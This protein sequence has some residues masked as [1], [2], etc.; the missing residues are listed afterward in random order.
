MTTESRGKRVTSADVARAAGVEVVVALL[1][2]SRRGRQVGIP[3]QT[4]GRLQA[5]HLAATG[6]R[7][8]GYAFP[9]NERVHTLARSRLSGVRHACAELGLAMPVVHTVP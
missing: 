6:H 7:H 4:I 2:R 8:L 1:D 9:D 3:H 5:E